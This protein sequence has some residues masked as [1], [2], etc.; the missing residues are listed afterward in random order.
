M[1]HEEQEL[2]LLVYAAAVVFFACASEGAHRDVIAQPVNADPTPAPAPREDFVVG[3]GESL[4]RIALCTGVSLDY[5]A[6]INEIPDPDRVA[7][8]ARLR[9][10]EGHDCA[11][12]TLSADAARA[13][14]G[15]LLAA[16]TARLD[17]ADFEGALS[18]S[19]SCVQNLVPYELDAQ[20]K[21]LRARCHVVAGSAATGL[22]RS[23]RAIAEL[24]HALEL[25]PNLELDADTTSPRI[26]DM[27]SQ[28]RSD[29]A[30]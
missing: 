6:L 10:P 30:R 24:R 26:L 23:D 2:R 21:A 12:E 22:D 20:A 15:R 9:L 4:Y 8:G 19:E 5:L 18:L 17:A 3:E 11:R 7:A 1:K 29:A 14:A 13:R 28:L 25:D 27:V 16:A